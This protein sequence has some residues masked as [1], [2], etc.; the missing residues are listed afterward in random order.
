MRTY[1]ATAA[2]VLLGVSAVSAQEALK[3][4]VIDVQRVVE[5]SA[6]GKEMLGRL[7][8]LRNEK[9]A[10]ARKMAESREALVRQVNTQRA[11]LS[12]AKIAE[13]QKQAED[14]DVQLRRFDQDAQDELQRAQA[15]EFGAL[16]KKIMPVITEVGR[17]M[18]LQLIFNKFQSG[19][20][21]ADEA[22]DITDQ[23]LR[24]F[25]TLVTK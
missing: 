15:S 22:V 4:A 8:K 10:E 18:K 9:Q 16:E 3:I 25:N 21:Y 7:Q 17:E 2:A 5:D 20:V 19:L 11:T 12:D 1:L 24:R 13:L 6:A 14:I 23:V